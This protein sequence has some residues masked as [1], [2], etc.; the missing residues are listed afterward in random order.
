MLSSVVGFVLAA[1][2]RNV[3]GLERYEEDERDGAGDG[4]EL[5]G[6]GRIEASSSASSALAGDHIE[7]RAT[8]DR[9][10][11]VDARSASMECIESESALR[12]MVVRRCEAS[13]TDGWNCVGTDL[14]VC[15]R[16]M[17]VLLLL[18]LSAP[19]VLSRLER[20]VPAIFRW[21]QCRRG[22]LERADNFF[23]CGE[24]DGAWCC[25]CLVISRLVAVGGEGGAEIAD[26]GIGLRK[27]DREYT[28][29]RV[30]RTTCNGRGGGGEQTCVACQ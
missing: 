15:R 3:W 22:L 23:W 12:D 13:V 9:S 27:R 19:W 30:A 18:P 10:S 14:V 5:G 8:E 26:I 24:C 1:M 29:E 11:V 17:D 16:G 6:I 21:N 20:T 4:G 28:D 7:S 25:R 2:L